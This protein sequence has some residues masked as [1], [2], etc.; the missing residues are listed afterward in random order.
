MPA[1]ITKSTSARG[2]NRGG[3][4]GGYERTNP[5]YNA[6]RLRKLRADYDALEPQWRPVFLDSLT[7]F[8]RAYVTDRRIET[9]QS[10]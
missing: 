6:D 10:D 4:G 2:S 9:P 8:E 3:V 1:K 7:K 5:E